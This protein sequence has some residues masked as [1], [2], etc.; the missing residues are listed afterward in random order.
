MLIPLV[1][2]V[3]AAWLLLSIVAAML[4]GRAVH[5]ADRRRPRSRTTAR[6]AT[7]AFGRVVEIATGAIPIIRPATFD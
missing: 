4:I 1:V 7:S 2:S 5:L 3:V 6:R